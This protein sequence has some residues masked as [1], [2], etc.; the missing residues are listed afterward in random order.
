MA[1]MSVLSL[2]LQGSPEADANVG[3]AIEE[4]CQLAKKL[5]LQSVDFR[6]S[7][8]GFICCYPDRRATRWTD[9]GLESWNFERKRFEVEGVK[10]CRC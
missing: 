10:E 6:L 3:L 2:E 1:V 4:G 5:G 9:K 7:L 8:F